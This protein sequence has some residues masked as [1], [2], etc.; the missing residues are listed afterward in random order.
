[1]ENSEGII[2]LHYCLWYCTT[3]Q[4][5]F[6]FKIRQSC[7]TNGQNS[8]M[9]SVVYLSC[10]LSWRRDSFFY[11]IIYLE[12]SGKNI[13]NFLFLWLSLLMYFYL[14]IF[15]GKKETN[16]EVVYKEEHYLPTSLKVSCGSLQRC[17]ILQ[18]HNICLNLLAFPN[19]TYQIFY[20]TKELCENGHLC[21]MFMSINIWVAM[22]SLTEQHLYSPVQNE[23]NMSQHSIRF[24]HLI[25]NGDEDG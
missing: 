14:Y 10:I 23:K 6:G 19:I 8:L 16:T 20:C 1:M 22:K 11:F 4:Q 25:Q 18:G 9:E 21:I 17:D 2:T 24:L 7:F 13:N 5:V 12:C 15:R 3:C